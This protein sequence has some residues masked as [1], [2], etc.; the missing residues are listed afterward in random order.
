MTI[1]RFSAQKTIP[2]IH[3]PKKAFFYEKIHILATL[4]SFDLKFGE[5]ED[6]IKNLTHLTH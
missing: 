2:V 4:D 6:I 5:V 1:R 3:N